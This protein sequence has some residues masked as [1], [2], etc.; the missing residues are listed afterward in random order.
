MLGHPLVEPDWCDLLQKDF[1]SLTLSVFL[2][3]VGIITATNGKVKARRCST[4]SKRQV[5]SAARVYGCAGKGQEKHRR[6]ASTD[7]AQERRKMRSDHSSEGRRRNLSSP[8]SRR[9]EVS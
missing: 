2:E 6:E 8:V 3:L 1:A 9:T 4:R 7:V 5:D